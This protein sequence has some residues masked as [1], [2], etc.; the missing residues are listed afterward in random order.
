MK[1]LISL[2]LCLCLLMAG[3]PACVQAEN[4]EADDIRVPASG[5]SFDFILR[6]HPEALS[7][8]VSEKAGGYADLL[9]SLRFHGT[10]VWSMDDGFEL[11]VSV[12][13]VDSR[14]EPISFRFYGVDGLISVNS[15]LLGEKAIR[16]SNY[17]LLGFCSKMSEHLGIPLHDLALLYPFTWEYCLK[18]PIQDWQHFVNSIDENGAVSEEGVWYLSNCWEWRIRADEPTNILM[19]ALCKESDLEEAFRAMITDIPDY[20]FKQVAGE[21]G[22][23]VRREG[24]Q[25]VWH[26]AAGD[27]LTEIRNENT[28]RI[29]LNLPEMAVGYLPVFSMDQDIQENSQSWHL[30]AQILG[31]DSLREDLFSLEAS[32]LNFP[33]SWPSDFHSLLSL[34]LTGGL[35][36]NIGFSAYITG[37][38]NGYSRMEIRKPTVNYEPGPVLLTAEGYLNPLEGDVTIRPYDQDNTKGELDLLIANDVKIQEFL[39]DIVRPMLE[40]LV[41][42]LVGIPTSACQT[43]MD[44]LTNLGILDLLLG[45]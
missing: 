40:G 18:V 6:L 4:G 44:D 2:A 27:F 16:L 36:P 42:F 19:D 20:I 14:G 37:E 41:R 32:L 38:E 33:V 25:T 35:L 45:Q 39:P 11:N 26:A 12:I 8:S 31:S 10:Y 9:Q 30:R 43:I 15:S 34:S 3:L 28:W 24:D 22:I 1:K 7:D 23:Q 5:Y 29:A 13:P 21:Q 17:S